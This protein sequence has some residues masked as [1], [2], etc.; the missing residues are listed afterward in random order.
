MPPERERFLAALDR[1]VERLD[2]PVAI[3]LTVPWHERSAAELA[4]RHGATRGVP[5]AGVVELALG[6]ADETVFW[7]PEHLALVTG[8][9]LLGD[10]SGGV[11]LCPESW[12]D[13]DDPALLRGALTPLLD[14][15]IERLL[16]SHGDPVLADGKAALVRALGE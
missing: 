7:I 4:E 1:D 14:L 10:R 5:P 11:E 2:R 16:V 9:A 13:G 15:P 3:L 6:V 8:D 12:L